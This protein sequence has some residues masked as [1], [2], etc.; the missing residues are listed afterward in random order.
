MSRAS[1]ISAARV[2]E[3]R[4]RSPFATLDVAD[5]LAAAFDG[6]SDAMLIGDHEGVCL[7]ANHAAR[8][9]FD[10]PGRTV[11]GARIDELI[12]VPFGGAFEAH[13]GAPFRAGEP[14]PRFEVTRSDDASRALIE[15]VATVSLASGRQLVTLRDVTDRELA[16]V[17]LQSLLSAW[18]ASED[19][20]IT[21]SPD[22]TI[23]GWNR[24]AEKLYGYSAH[25]VVGGSREIIIPSDELELARERFQTVLGG[26]V[27]ARSEHLRITKDGRT[28][29]VSTTLMPVKLATGEV[30]GVTSI[31]HDVTEQKLGDAALVE[32]HARAVE[33]SRLR[34]EFIANMNHE[35]RTPMNGVIGIT[36][37]LADTALD[38]EQ[39]DYIEALKV[40]GEALLAVINDVLDFSKIEA[41]KVTLNETAF[42]PRELLEDVRAIVIHGSS[43]RTPR[44]AITFD[45]GVPRLVI[46][47]RD[48][49]RQ[50]LLNLTNNAVKFTDDGQITVKVTWSGEPG[51]VGELRVEVTDTGIG[52]DEDAQSIIFKSFAQAD[53]SM[54]RRYGGTG[55]GLTIAKE[56]VELM[57]GEIGVHSIPGEG[58]TFW[59]ALPMLDG[60]EDDQSDRTEGVLLGLEGARVIVVD[61]D[62]DARSAIEAQLRSSYVTVTTAADGDGALDALRDAARA[63]QPYDVAL[64]DGVLADG[65]LLA[66]IRSDSA[67]ASLRVVVMAPAG[68]PS[69]AGIDGS[70]TTPADPAE[71]YAEIVRVIDEP[72]TA[73]PPLRH[74]VDGD[75]E[76]EPEPALGRV[77]VAEDNLVNQLVTVRL[78]EIRGFAVDVAS[79]GRRAVDMHTKAPY[80]VIFMDCQMPELD[81][82][83]A[84]REIRRYDGETRHTP[85]IAVTANTLPGDAER[86]F[87]AGMDAFIGKPISSAKLD[88]TI[89]EALAA[90]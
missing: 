78:L 82:Y 36:Q 61:G 88:E 39:R 21:C 34:A 37:L 33:A 47:D 38:D 17:H 24:G 53:G 66:A 80:D 14:R 90:G 42:D 32:A 25:E 20:V 43:T 67:L 4:L 50:V 46:G 60:R 44:L 56:L 23:T 72:D 41:H 22:G 35:L 69:I 70:V 1:R 28:L 49:I 27:F 15:L 45:A 55:L 19:A 71:L 77:L 13:E 10:A 79:D 30:V 12:G 76:V 48:R 86:C 57:G 51:E 65:G 75:V 85:I 74:A 6:A 73:A 84:T 29:T 26:E 8:T 3:L 68:T 63:A 59:F 18:D 11:I 5:D 40:S 83:D 87:E 2:A 16:E 64:V 58:S 89:A 52:I 9:L 81:G 54:A 31:G 7:Y 62:G